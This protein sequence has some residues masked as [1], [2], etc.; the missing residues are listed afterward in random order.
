MREEKN[1]TLSCSICGQVYPTVKERNACETACLKKAEQNARA[2]KNVKKREIENTIRNV[3]T[4]VANYNKE[5]DENLNVN[6]EVKT[7]CSEYCFTHI[8]EGMDTNTFIDNLTRAL[9]FTR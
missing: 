1:E 4:L 2:L 5:F 8:N 9:S 3:K 7:N 6:I